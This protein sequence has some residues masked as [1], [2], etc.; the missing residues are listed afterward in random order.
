MKKISKKFIAGL[1]NIRYEETWLFRKK[2]QCDI[3]CDRVDLSNNIC[4]RCWNKVQ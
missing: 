4:M 2:L 1:I 3:V